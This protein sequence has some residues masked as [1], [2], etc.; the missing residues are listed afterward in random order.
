MRSTRTVSFLTVT[1]CVAAMAVATMQV[2]APPA[3]PSFT[4][5]DVRPDRG[6]VFRVFAPRADEV[7]LVGTDIPRNV[8]GIAMTKDDRGVW[9]TTVGPLEPGAYRY[10]FNVNGVA[11]IDPRSPSIS[12]SNNNVWSMVHVPGAE[13]MDTGD[14]PHGAVAAIMYPSS[15]LHKVRRMHIYTP[16]GYEVGTARYPVFYLLHGA[17]DSDESW[18]SV[19]RAGFILDNLIAAKKAVPMIVVMPAGHT[20][21]TPIGRGA[22]PQS[23]GEGGLTPTEEFVK[24]FVEDVMPYVEKNY[25]VIA[26]RPHRAIAGLSMGGNQTLNIAIEHLDRFTYVGVFSSG[27]IGALGR[28]AAPVAAPPPPGAPP[29]LDAAWEQQH[30][31]ALDNAAARKGLKAFWFATGSEDRLM[32]TTRATIELFKRHG[33][34]PTFTESGGGH[35]W[36]NWRDYLNAFAPQLF[37]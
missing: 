3:P 11:V 10:N 12:E 7:R 32:P 9:E 33:F 15:A 20:S 28:G 17:G 6:V 22:P 34:N 14:V 21:R 2:P 13:F 19:G 30:A 18:T 16:P 24:D 8:Q 36:A 37:H 4:S 26:D 25:R 35:T 1:I 23:A 5:P 29:V 27:L 31:A